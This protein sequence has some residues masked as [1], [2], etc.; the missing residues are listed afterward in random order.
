MVAYYE[1]EAAVVAH[2]GTVV[3]LCCGGFLGVKRWDDD[4]GTTYLVMC[5]LFFLT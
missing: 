1:V 4:L 3:L 2:F 5:V